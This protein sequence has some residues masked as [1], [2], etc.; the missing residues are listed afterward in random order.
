VLLGATLVYLLSVGVV[1]EFQRRVGGEV[2]LATLWKG[3]QV[4]LSILWA[5]LGGAAFV[6]GAVRRLTPLRLGGLG[7]LVL[8]TVKVFLVDLAS[9][10]ATYRV[11]SFIVLGLF[12]LASSYV[13]QRLRPQRRPEGAH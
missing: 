12:L 4:A 2:P 5:G 1:D 3:A 8:A 10:D 11:P 7:L 13:Y 9:L 6:G